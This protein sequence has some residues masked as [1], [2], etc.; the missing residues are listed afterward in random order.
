MLILGSP[1]YDKACILS[2]RE[3][4][5]MSYANKINSYTILYV[6]FKFPE[7]VKYPSIPCTLDE[8]IT[9]YPLEGESYITSLE[10]LVAF[11][12]GANIIVK[13]IFYIPFK[14]VK[15]TKSKSKS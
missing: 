6:K 1:D 2:E 10:Y 12:Q 5:K 7:N 14:K 11:R 8:N 15:E 13:E 9:V 3:F 4:E